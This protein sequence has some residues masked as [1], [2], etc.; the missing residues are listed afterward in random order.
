M[1]N[2]EQTNG[3]STPSTPTPSA[4]L[5]TPDQ[6]P[7]TAIMV[8]TLEFPRVQDTEERPVVRFGDRKESLRIS[9]TV[10]VEI[11]SFWFTGPKVLKL[12]KMKPALAAVNKAGNRMPDGKEYNAKWFDDNVRDPF[13]KVLR[14]CAKQ[15]QDHGEP[16]SVGFTR[17]TVKSTGEQI[18]T[19][20][21][22]FEFKVKLPAAPAIASAVQQLADQAKA[23]EEK[24]REQSETRSKRQKGK[25]KGK[26]IQPVI[27]AEAGNRIDAMIAETEAAK[28]ATA[29]GAPASAGEPVK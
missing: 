28:A 6:Q 12:K 29:N 14:F 24:A 13:H 10:T 22:G 16:V 25:G 21:H 8:P 23:N 2:N 18:V 15:S 17:R 9:E 11:D 3:E 7:A 1:K 5:P 26:G 27:N 4:P 19:A 20:K